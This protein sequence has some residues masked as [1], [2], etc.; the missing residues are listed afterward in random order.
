MT[1]YPLGEPIYRSR[2]ADVI[3]DP[4]LGVQAADL[5]GI[6][7]VLSPA[8]AESVQFTWGLTQAD[9]ALLQ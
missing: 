3:I 7:E 6:P 8:V 4:T 9:A 2:L 1:N 5:S